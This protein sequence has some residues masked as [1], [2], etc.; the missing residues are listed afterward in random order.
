MPK[1]VVDDATDDVPDES[2]GQNARA[3]K[4]TAAKGGDHGR[5]KPHERL[6]APPARG[7]SAG[8][9]IAVTF[10]SRDAKYRYWRIYVVAG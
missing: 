10:G 2:M 3:R 9:P 5:E 8:L 4:K 1:A 7:L 6:F